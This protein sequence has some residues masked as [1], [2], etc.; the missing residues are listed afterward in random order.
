MILAEVNECDI[1]NGG[2]EY[3]CE[4]TEGSYKCSCPTNFFLNNDGHN[5]TGEFN[6][7]HNY[8]NLFPNFQFEIT[9]L[10]NKNKNDNFE[11]DE[12]L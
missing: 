6:T 8:M 1:N 5:C 9:I 2:C 10:R 11:T 7:Y 12:D 4:N 3:N